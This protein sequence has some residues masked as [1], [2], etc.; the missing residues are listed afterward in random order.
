MNELNVKLAKEL[1]DSVFEG[2]EKAQ[3]LAVLTGDEDLK[4][5][6]LMLVTMLQAQAAGDIKDIADAVIPVLSQKIE[7]RSGK[8]TASEDLIKGLNINLN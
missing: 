4:L 3:L 7:A 2:A 1:I 8:A 5:L 6:A